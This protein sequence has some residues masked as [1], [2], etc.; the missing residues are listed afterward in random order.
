MTKDGPFRYFK[1][2]PLQFLSTGRDRIRAAVS[3]SARLLRIGGNLRSIRS[4]S[5]RN[6]RD[7]EIATY[8]L[9]EA[10][11]SGLSCPAHAPQAV[12]AFV[13]SPSTISRTII[14]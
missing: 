2:S 4:M 10:Y 11:N 1:T 14:L 6:Q 9:M 3:R 8:E 12:N 13:L 7:A 5:S